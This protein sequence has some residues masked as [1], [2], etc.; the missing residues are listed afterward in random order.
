MDEIERAFLI[1]EDYYGRSLQRCHMVQFS[2][3]LK[4]TAGRAAYAWDCSPLSI[5]LSIPVMELNPEE[6]ISRT[7][8][9]EAAHLIIA[10]VYGIETAPHGKKW[11]NLMRV[12]ERDG[13]TKH[14]MKV[15]RKEYHYIASCGT[16]VTLLSGRH[17]NIQQGATYV[18]RGGGKITREGLVE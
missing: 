7:P 3:R 14:S 15:V 12:L 2:R 13:S 18:L 11:K 4:V 10:Q 6:F 9:H 16:P 1:A 8:A 17:R 5:K